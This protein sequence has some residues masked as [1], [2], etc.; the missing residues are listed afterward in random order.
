M[1]LHA[2]SQNN[3]KIMLKLSMLVKQINMNDLL[4][5]SNS[6]LFDDTLQAELLFTIEERKTVIPMQNLHQLFT[7]A[8]ADKLYDNDIGNV[9]ANKLAYIK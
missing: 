8:L 5:F 4:N 3:S 9:S 1:V 6:N 7:T 2:L